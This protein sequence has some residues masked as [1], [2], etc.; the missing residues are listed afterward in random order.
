MM[1][2]NAGITPK[3]VIERLTKERDPIVRRN[4]ECVLRHQEAELRGDLEGIM[5]TLVAEPHYHFYGMMDATGN[6]HSSEVKGRE[7]VRQMYVGSIANRAAELQEFDAYRVVADAFSVAYDGW[8][9]VPM[10]GK[11]LIALGYDAE[12]NAFYLNE[13][14][15]WTFWKFDENGLAV[16]EDIAFDAKTFIGILDRR[17]EID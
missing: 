17:I 13:G 6:I 10:I 12:P 4:L 2:F 5:A 11:T 8:L 9:R 1:K 15:H 7:A 14:M 3:A 16:G